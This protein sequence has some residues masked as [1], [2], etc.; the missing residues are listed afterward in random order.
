ML[1]VVLQYLIRAISRTIPCPNCKKA[2]RLRDF[3][4]AD[5][6]DGE[7]F[8]DVDCNNCGAQVS[9]IANVT[10]SQ[11]G[12]QVIQEDNSEI[13]SGGAATKTAKMIHIS[14]HELKTLNTI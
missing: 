4:V 13:N 5:L 14:K 7:I 8:M 12:I 9:I 2:F 10:Q 6:L 11:K 3:Y 1:F